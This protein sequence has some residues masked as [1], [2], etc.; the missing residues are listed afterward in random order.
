[1]IFLNNLNVYF[2]TCEIQYH[3]TCPC[4]THE[5]M[6]SIEYLHHQ[7]IELGLALFAHSKLPKTYWKDPFLTAT[8]I[9]N[10][11]PSKALANKSPFELAYH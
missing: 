1:M 7:I 8:F 5:K 3:L 6:G 11:L 10:R 9:I 2:K 4:Y